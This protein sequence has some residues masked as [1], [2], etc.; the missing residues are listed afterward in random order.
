MAT[1]QSTVDVILDQLAPLGDVRARKMFGEYALYFAGKV[2]GLICDDTLFIKITEPGH[3]MMGK[4]QKTG[5]AY[6]GAKPSFQIAPEQIEDADWLGQV[7][8]V[9]AE[10][11]PA[12]LRKKKI[13]KV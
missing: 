13:K 10:H 3:A 9:T 12:P 6:P 2:V 1:K 7:V 5:C 8:R 11:L 4:N